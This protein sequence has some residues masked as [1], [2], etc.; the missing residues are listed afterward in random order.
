MTRRKQII[1]ELFGT[2]KKL[3]E[4]LMGIGEAGPHTC[5]ASQDCILAEEPSVCQAVALASLLR[6]LS[7]LNLYPLPE[8]DH[9]TGSI[10]KLYNGLRTVVYSI[11]TLEPKAPR[12]FLDHFDCH[13]KKQWYDELLKV[14]LANQVALV[15]QRH[16]THMNNQAR[17]FADNHKSSGR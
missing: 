9:Y 17:N 5:V 14:A 7:G 2:V 6:G 10:K 13:G 3:L 8:P 4:G 15:E 11:K 1:T 12:Q 16:I